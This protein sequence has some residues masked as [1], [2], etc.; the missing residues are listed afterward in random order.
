MPRIM[1][2]GYLCSRCGHRW[3][4]RILGG[5]SP[6]QCPACRSLNWDLSGSDGSNCKRVSEAARRLAAM[7]GSA[8]DLEYIPRRRGEN[9]S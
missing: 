1:I 5:S 4:P 2:E 9:V 7:G 8:P 6:K 3:A